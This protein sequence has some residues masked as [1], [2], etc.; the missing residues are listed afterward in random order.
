[1]LLCTFLVSYFHFKSIFFSDLSTSSSSRSSSTSSLSDCVGDVISSNNENETPSSEESSSK[2]SSSSSSSLSHHD[3]SELLTGSD[4]LDFEEALEADEHS[5]FETD[6]KHEGY[7]EDL[8]NLTMVDYNRKLCLINELIRL[9]KSK[10]SEKDLWSMSSE[11]AATTAAEQQHPLL[12][13][14]TKAN[15]KYFN[16]KNEEETEVQLEAQFICY[17]ELGEISSSLESNLVLYN[18]KQESSLH[19]SDVSTDGDRV[20]VDNCN[21][22]TSQDL[23]DWFITRQIDDMPVST[24]KFP[25][26]SVIN[27]GKCLR[28]DMP[29]VNDQLNFLRAIR[30][31]QIKKSEHMHSSD[32]KKAFLKIKTRL[33]TSDGALKD[34]HTQEIPQFY[35]EIFKYANLIK[36]L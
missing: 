34:M 33:I 35:H 25:R 29:F 27:A 7:D 18:V 4:N 36:F 17:K 24:Y 31:Q 12:S 32:L 5:V 1:M 15:I 26:G 8:P 23:S 6:G 28:I 21:L 14:F 16:L 30:N 11:E 2:S 13:N 20:C 10:M 3:I 9:H 22:K 19:L